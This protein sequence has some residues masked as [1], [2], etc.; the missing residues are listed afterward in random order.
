[1]LSI[2]SSVG[3]NGISDTI[4]LP[5]VLALKNFFKKNYKVENIK[6]CKYK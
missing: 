2:I 1:M 6:M 3:E 5:A 4:K